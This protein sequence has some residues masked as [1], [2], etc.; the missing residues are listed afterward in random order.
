MSKRSQ[1]ILSLRKENIPTIPTTVQLE[2]ETN[3]FFRCDNQDI[4]NHIN[5]KNAESEEVFT[6]LRELKD[7][8]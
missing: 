8:F 4:K 5:M 7:N 6:K 1:N 2:K 3:I